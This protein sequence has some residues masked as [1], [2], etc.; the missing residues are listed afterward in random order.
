MSPGSGFCMGLS[1]LAFLLILTCPWQKV[2]AVGPTLLTFLIG[3]LCPGRKLTLTLRSNWFS[4]LALPA[5]FLVTSS[6]QPIPLGCSAHRPR[7]WTCSFCCSLY[8]ILDGPS[9]QGR[10]LGWGDSNRKLDPSDT[11]YEEPGTLSSPRFSCPP[12]PSL[13]RDRFAD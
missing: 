12:L 10:L 8:Q 4:L 11:W 5:V 9:P 13:C 7:E 1:N 6:S 3:R 2:W